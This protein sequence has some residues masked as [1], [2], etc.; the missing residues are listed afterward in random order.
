MNLNWMPIQIANLELLQNAKNAKNAKNTTI[1]DNDKGVE[2]PRFP[3][4]FWKFQKTGLR[5]ELL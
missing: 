2:Q 4:G 1:V 5:S 3:N